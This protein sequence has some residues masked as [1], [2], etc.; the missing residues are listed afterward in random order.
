MTKK[1]IVISPPFQA[2]PQGVQ[3]GGS[4]DPQD[5][6]KYLLY[7]DEIDYPDNNIISIG[8]SDDLSFLE[9]CGV[10][11]RTRIIFQ[12]SG[13]IDGTVF[14]TAQEQAFRNNEKQEQGKWSLAQL[15][16]NQFYTN[17]LPETGVEFELLNCLPVPQSDVPLNDILE[18]K[19]KRNS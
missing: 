11:K 6:R 13:L 8:L 4:P 14:I 12:G 19:Q 16:T 18:F 10:L 1:G 3:C 2:L 5:V 15:S 9:G 17:T 7:W